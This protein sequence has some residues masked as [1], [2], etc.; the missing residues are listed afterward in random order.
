MHVTDSVHGPAL[1]EGASPQPVPGAGEVLVRVYAA[2]VTVT[3][4]LWYPTSHTKTGEKRIGAV[5]CHEFCGV[6]AA[7]GPDASGLE[8]GQE[9]FGMND[10]YAE[11]ALAEYCL[12][13][14]SAVAPKPGGI[15]HTD[16]ASLPIPG[17]TAW[18][19]LIDRAKVQ[20]GERVLVQG[21]AGA[22]GVFA[23]QLAKLRAAHVTATASARN[24]DFVSSLGADQVID[25]KKTR[26]EDRVQNV[27]VVFDT[28]GGDILERSWGVLRPCGRMV[29]VAST[30]E[31]STD[32]RAKKAFFIVETNRDQL[33]EIACLVSTGRLQTVVDTVVPFSQAPEAFTDRL[34]RRGRGKLVVE[35]AA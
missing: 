2:G 35:V 9:V 26:F 15:S 14:A 13:P 32:E 29:T 12:A 6:V 17:L 18:Q 10:W 11:G 7:V 31:S 28:V 33:S 1:V 5:P 30:A 25:Y 21:G 20:P 22:V 4:L 34:Q 24:V 19:G 16:A 8:I 23:V 3:E 27:D